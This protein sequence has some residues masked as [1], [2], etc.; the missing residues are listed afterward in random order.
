MVARTAETLR[1][2]EVECYG[3]GVYSLIMSNGDTYTASDFVATEDLKVA[4]LVKNSTGVEL[5]ASILNNVVTCNTAGITNQK[6][7]LFVFG[8]RA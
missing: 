2:N 3:Y 7:T 1:L 5:T 4:T 6:C 8:V